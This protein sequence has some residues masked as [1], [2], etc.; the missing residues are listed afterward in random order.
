MKL[1]AFQFYSL[2]KAFR[3]A[4]PYNIWPGKPPGHDSELEDFAI[5]IWIWLLRGWFDLAHGQIPVAG[6][7]SVSPEN[8]ADALAQR[9]LPKSSSNDSLA[10]AE[11]CASPFVSNLDQM[12][13]NGLFLLGEELKSLRPAIKVLSRVVHATVALP[14]QAVA[15]KV[16]Q[17]VADTNQ[18]VRTTVALAEDGAATA[19]HTSGDEPGPL[20]APPNG[21]SSDL[22][23]AKS[24][25]TAPSHENISHAITLKATS[26]RIASARR[27]QLVKA[28]L[29]VVP[30]V[31]VSGNK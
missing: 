18:V 5:L 9:W 2:P 17:P 25:S 31:L 13:E 19:A 23:P 7:S 8:T 1:A 29:R 22:L 10:G 24:S 15:A 16:Q 3:I 27:K 11:A 28:L 14:G 12:L 26:Y 6:G 21:E 30:G 4:P 20:P